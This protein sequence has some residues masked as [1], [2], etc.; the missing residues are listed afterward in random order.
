MHEKLCLSAK[1]LKKSKSFAKSS[2]EFFKTVKN[3]NEEFGK[4]NDTSYAA[5]IIYVL[6]AK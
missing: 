6:Q 1:A 2:F 4:G 5:Q 3:Y